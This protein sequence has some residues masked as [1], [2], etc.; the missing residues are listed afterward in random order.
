M[1]Y[2]SALIRILGG[3]A[4][5]L[6]RAKKKKYTDDPADA[7]ANDDDG[8]VLKSDKSFSDLANEAKRDKTK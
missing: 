5:V 2:L 1:N 7:I 8:G 4:D 6:N 3:I